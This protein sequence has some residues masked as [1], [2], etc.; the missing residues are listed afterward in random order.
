MPAFRDTRHRDRRGAMMLLMGLALLSLVAFAAIVVDV[1]YRIVAHTELQSAADAAAL[2]A[3]GAMA[4]DDG[5]A[6][7]RQRGINAAQLYTAA[8]T[9]SGMNNQALSL[10]S[11]DIVF[12][13][14]IYQPT[15]GQWHFSSPSTQLVPTGIRV[16]VRRDNI[17]NPGV[18][19]YFARIWNQVGAPVSATSQ[20]MVAPRDIVVV[21]DL[22]RS[23]TDDS[24]LDNRNAVQINL[25]DIWVTL[26]SVA[27]SPVIRTVAGAGDFPAQ[28]ALRT[29]TASAY[30]S[31]Q[32]RTFGSMVTWGTNILP[33]Q[34]NQ[35]AVTN[36]L[37]MYYLPRATT[38]RAVGSLG[39]VDTDPRYF[40]L[41]LN[42]SNPR[43]LINRYTTAQIA[44]IMTP[45]DGG[46][47]STANYRARVQVVLGLS[48]WVDADA[49]RRVEPGEV[50]VVDDEYYNQGAGWNDWID[51]VVG[52]YGGSNY[53]ASRYGLKAYVN[54]LM[55]VG[56]GKVA[57]TEGSTGYT[58]RLQFTPITKLQACK[59]AMLEL[60][61]ELKQVSNADESEDRVGLV[62]FGTHS[63]ND[64]YSQTNGLTSDF[65]RIAD[66]PYP[67][68]P[69]EY[70]P[71]TNSAE[72][73]LYGYM[74]LNGP[75]SRPFA[76]KTLIFMT[77]GQPTIYNNFTIV[78]P[79][80][81]NRARLNAVTTLAAFRTLFGGIPK[82]SVSANTNSAR[83]E[84]LN[85][86]RILTSG[87]LGMGGVEIVPVAVGSDADMTGFMTP[88]GA[89]SG[90]AAYLAAPDI[91]DPQVLANTLKLI[92]RTIATQRPIAL[93][94]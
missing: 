57:N 83:T 26:E 61:T 38:W 70:G 6:T 31:V 71:S 42:T 4:T 24:L 18:P 87:M 52:G 54:W 59:D 60:A 94:H 46:S 17:S 68:Q 62:V 7:Y 79:T 64:P 69:G 74:M 1:G 55:D 50:T 36:D 92:F 30:A 16:T 9:S 29:E 11:N 65:D 77:D 43:A 49:D 44:D 82:A 81:A 80:T 86:G 63:A 8:H 20:A 78:L 56:Y 84:A 66:L 23:M 40:W 58:P 90:N 89:M 19:Y 47:E 91:N 75:G 72:A 48:D 27:A 76:H 45:R 85:V 88:L 37:G 35:T 14:A 73:L 39:T 10:N 51:Y 93:I 15:N 32:G 2:A 33:N 3:V 5:S 34:Y 12:G 25:R 13:D 21:M 28:Y 53:F 67:H 41:A 22:S